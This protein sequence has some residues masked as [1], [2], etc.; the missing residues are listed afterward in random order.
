MKH[1]KF[2]SLAS[3]FVVSLA[4]FTLI[5]CAD[6]SSTDTPQGPGDLDTSFQTLGI[7]TSTVLGGTWPMLLQP[8]G[9]VLVGGDFTRY[10]GS[11]RKNLARI[12]ADGSV[13]TLFDAG[14]R[15]GGAVM[16][17]QADG[18]IIVGG[19]LARLNA[20]GTADSSFTAAAFAWGP[21]SAQFNCITLQPDGKILVGGWFTTVASAS[22]IGLVRLNADGSLDTGFDPANLYTML[23]GPLCIAVQADGKIL[24]GGS[25]TKGIARLNAD[26]SLD[27]SFVPGAGAAAGSATARVHAIALQAD[28]SIL[29]GGE[30]TSFDGTPRSGIVRLSSTG[31]L[32]SSFDPGAGI[33]TTFALETA[34]VN[35]I[36]VQ[37]DGK[38]LV[39]GS[40]TSYNG[41]ARSNLARLN[42]DGTLDAGFD[43]GKNAGTGVS[44]QG[45]SGEF[46]DALAI[47][48]D[49]KVLVGGFFWL[50]YDHPN[51]V[52]RLF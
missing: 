29:V 24:V 23:S 48:S 36:A 42:A 19:P 49:G 2:A 27:A 21:S 41:S 32:D 26:G 13:D 44:T 37:S 52:V 6:S 46:V 14:S 25:S 3:S 51:I 30:F 11:Y 35:A 7:Y 34:C 47:Q 50:I 28:G 39:G 10:G 4:L 22:R 16:A 9:K 33:A 38:I 43:P 5:S 15:A 40:F 8:D 20:D 31:A 17:L 12:N 45:Y 1:G 18:K